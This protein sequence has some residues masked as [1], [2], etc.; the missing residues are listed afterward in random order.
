M[1]VSYLTIVL[2]C[3]CEWTFC[4]EGNPSILI[5][6][7]GPSGIAATTRLWK[8]NLTNLKVLEA[9]PRIGGRVNSV[10]FGDAYV[11]MG[12]EWCHGERGNIVYDMVKEYNILKHR[13]TPYKLKYSN[14]NYV[15]DDVSK[16]LIQFS[17]AVGE[18]IVG[19]E[20]LCK[21]YASTGECLDKEFTVTMQ[22]KFAHDPEKLKVSV[23]ANDWLQ[24]Y[25]KGYDSCFS[26]YDLHVKSDY[27]QCEG[28]L[29]IW[30]K[31]ARKV[32]V[33]C[34]DHSSF[35]ADHVI[36]TPSLGVLKASHEQLFQPG[37]PE[38]KVN[39]I[40]TAG[41]GAI[42][43]IILHFPETWWK[44]DEAFGLVW[45]AEDE[46]KIKTEFGR[47][48][49]KDGKSWL[50]SLA[51]LFTAENNPKVLVVFFAG[52]MIPE[53]EKENDQVLIDGLMYTFK[54]FFGKNNTVVDPDKMIKS[55]WYNNPHFRGTY[56]Y[57]SIQGN[58]VE[59]KFPDKL[60]APLTAE[61][62][63]PLV[64]FAG[65]AT[66]PHHF[67]TVHGAIETGYREADRLIELYT[68]KVERIAA[69]TKLWKANLT[70][71]KV[72]EAEP[73]I[74]GRVNSVKFGDG[75]IDLGGEWCHETH[76]DLPPLNQG[77]ISKIEAQY[78]EMG[79]VR[80][81]PS[82]RQ[83]VV[84]DDT[85]LNLLLALEE[86]PI[87]PAR[88]LA[89]DS[90][91]NHKTVL[92]I[93]KFNAAFRSRFETDPDRLK[94]CLEADDWLKSY[95]LSYE[96]SFSLYDVNVDSDFQQCEGD[97]GLNW[98]GRGY[99]TILEVMM[100]KFPD[101]S[102]HLP[103][104]NR[105]LLNKEVN[106]NHVIFTPSLGVL[107]A[108][109]EQLFEPGLPKEKVNAIKTTGFGAVLK[110]ILHFPETWWNTSEEFGFVWSTE[111]EDKIATEFGKGPVKNGKSWLTTLAYVYTAENNPKVL[112]TYFA[113]NMI[114]EIEK[115]NDQVLIDGLMYT[116]KKFLGKKH[117]VVDPDKMIKSTWYNNPHFRG[118]YSYDSIQGNSVE[119][120]F[121]IK[122]AAPLTAEDGMPL[123]QFAGE[124]TNSH[125]FSTVHGAIETGYREADRLIKL[126][127]KKIGGR[128]NSVKFGDGY[129]DLG[130]EWCHGEKGNIVYDMVKQYNILKHS[131]ATY[132]IMYSNG[133]SCYVILE[134]MMQKFP[135]SS[136]HLPLDNR[137]L[138]NKEVNKV[139]WNKDARK[140]TVQCSD[141]SSF[142]ADHVI[143]T[144]SLGVLKANH[145][146]L[147][148][149][150]LPKEKVNAIKTTGFGA[151][152]KIILHFPETW[153]NTSEEF[154]FVW[155]TED[156]DKIATEFGKGPVKNGKSWLTTLAYVYTAE[157]NP[158]VLM[159]YFAGNMIPEIEKEN[160]Q[161]LIDGLM[162]TF[163]KFLGKKHA[164]VDPDKM[165]KSTWYNNPHFRGTYSYDS[166]QGNSVEHKFPIKLAAPL[167]AEDG[168]PLVQFAGEATNSHHF[169]TV[170][171]AIE[172]GYREA[173]RLIK[174]YT[175]NNPSIVII[176]AGPSG[177]A[178]TTRFH[179]LVVL[180]A[181][182][183]IGGRLH[184]VKFGDAYVD[185]GGEWCHGEKGNIVY[186]MVKEYNILKHSNDTKYMVMYSNGNFVDEEVHKELMK[187]VG[188]L[189]RSIA[190]FVSVL[191]ITCA[192]ESPSIIIIG[193]GPSGIAAA[194]RLLKNN[195]TNVKVLEAENRI[196]GRIRSIQF[197]DA[198]VDLGA[199][200]CHGEKNNIVYDM[201]KDYDVLRHTNLSY[202][203]I[204]SDGQYVD[205]DI[206]RSLLLFV[207]SID[208]SVT[209]PATEEYCKNVSSIGDCFDILFNNTFTQRYRNDSRKLR[210]SLESADWLESYM[211]GYD[212]SF[213]LQD[214]S[215]KSS[216][217]RCE[218]DIR[219]NWNGHG[220]KTILEL[221]MQRFPNP[222]NELPIGSRIFLNKEVERIFWNRNN[223]KVLIQ[224]SDNTTYDG[225]QVIF[226][227]SLGV[228]KAEHKELFKPNLPD[229]KVTAVR[230]FG[231][232]AVFKIALHFPEVW[233]K[234]DELFGF[235][236]SEEDKIQIHKEFPFGPIKNQ[237]SWLTHSVKFFQAENNPNVLM[238][239]FSGDV[240]PDLEIEPDNVIIGGYRMIRSSWYSNPHFR[241]TFSYESVKGNSFG[242]RYP[243]KLGQPLTYEDGRPSVLFAGEATHPYY[244][245]TVHAAI[246]TGYREADRI[247]NLY[248]RM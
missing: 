248:R 122:L 126:Y 116:F 223:S 243:E 191:A 96:S 41:F 178:A 202:T 194:T 36:F 26:L 179:N 145:E 195:F 48:P 156:E 193:A 65:E 184:S 81:V 159:T 185:M 205:E 28:D 198:F 177:I 166:I 235:V 180:E 20:D 39:A 234:A 125:H 89:R 87:T 221:M 98:D 183:R 50:T 168:M 245:S 69:A 197:G 22:R 148:E 211:L 57:D 23:E 190:I 102:N 100:Q 137:I 79:H 244:F 112:M 34:S 44:T 163:K 158:K 131:N 74:G 212:S 43:K 83:A 88:Q 144:P 51:Y 4:S 27:D 118:T 171:G 146:Q 56:S 2:V 149:P 66:N 38:V 161:V 176:G 108:N 97:L 217:K 25:L 162:Y 64:Q 219:L 29:V 204:Y 9:E 229:E 151:V 30:N 80:K 101:S 94:V 91:L 173:D 127:T 181:E 189:S 110:I 140:V 111:D 52:N 238:V 226:T 1:F 237:R 8:A 40:K 200:W 169:S 15:D 92:K 187:F 239:F 70:N 188:S 206:R 77:T 18:T 209:N 93:L 6:G 233:W 35:E 78:R 164:V 107:K 121:P 85:K 117:A 120:K 132:K 196:G 19:E 33:Q 54:K 157:N 46:K 192:E 214:L 67:S 76:P 174:L 55:T 99:K 160:D 58:S 72:L 123:V 208:A 114:P 136:N 129:I 60:A 104:D 47:G 61:D 142:E 105:I 172:T 236:W 17:E 45:S 73:R 115:E 68:K 165:I 7:S 134:V 106:K 220:Y 49:V 155:S 207:D 133:D 75:Y 182:P 143:F 53:I 62:G 153:W 59:H 71:L 14:G 86:N 135:D 232:G 225:D 13:T 24:S 242:S 113:G 154:G 124:A 224:C 231:F 240:V 150:G 63:R 230:N 199:E 175:K 167:T 213:T 31:E 215:R 139:I 82:K 138:L 21:K 241:G 12:G 37:L 119:H 95:I 128:V 32:T 170:H 109:H 141:N 3:F 247:I 10:K 201:V 5:I 11:D 147:F 84:H 90:N 16:E 210:T 203:L 103:L 218:G 228:L 216:Y 152:L 130:G 222:S 246:E 227:P 186:D 42:L